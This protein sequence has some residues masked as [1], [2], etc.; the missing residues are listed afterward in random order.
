MDQKNQFII[1]Y[2]WRDAW[3]K[4]K[5]TLS[6][7]SWCAGRIIFSG[8]LF[9]FF[10]LITILSVSSRSL[11]AREE[12]NFLKNNN[13][14]VISDKAF[15][16]SK[17]STFEALGNVIITHKTNTIYSEKAS[18]NFETGEV[19]AIGNVRFIGP[20]ITMYGSVI[21]YN[22]KTKKLTIKNARVLSDNYIILGKKLSR[23][24]ENVII[25]EEAEYTTC[26]DCPESWSIFGK[27]IHI[28]LGEY[29]RIQHAYIK[30]KGV[31]SMYFPYLVFPIK[32]D[33][34]MGLLFPSFG[35]DLEEGVRFQQPWF[36]PINKSIDM[37]LTPSIFGKRGL[38]NEL[39][40]RHVLKDQF[41]YELNTFSINDRVYK[42]NSSNKSVSGEHHFRQMVDWEH[43]FFSGESFNHHF[44][45]NGVNDLDF[46]KDFSRFTKSRVQGTEYGGG[47]FATLRK[48][49]FTFSTE[50]HFNRNNLYFNPKGFDHRYVHI[51]PRLS[52][53]L[54]PIHLLQSDY[55]FLNR[56]SFLVDG[57]MTIFKQN[58]VAE[59]TYLR[60]A[61]RYNG[62]PKLEWNF[63]QFGVVSGKTKITLD[64]QHYRFPTQVEQKTFTK[65]GVIY[66]TEFSIELEKIYGLS[67]ENKVLTDRIREVKKKKA[68]QES[69]SEIIGKLP[70]YN[71][72]LIKK[73]FKYQKPSF[74]HSQIFKLK[75]YSIEALL[76][77]FEE[78]FFYN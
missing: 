60:N 28:T 63:G 29:V 77:Y 56:I 26:R 44:Y 12:F 19:K 4:L 10:L 2:R 75:H 36:L 14:Q 59:Q 18:I 50:G 53:S 24:S 64:Y 61:T 62:A 69:S 41:W 17:I 52:F 67:Y 8:N 7:H 73:Y 15:R 9:H 32:K 3:K 22:L 13:V 30:I 72:R 25:G 40:F 37:T 35:L 55:P 1:S 16:K 58:H 46:D 6:N 42:P 31:V 66:E 74:R 45:Y 54:I 21:E 49:W 65:S 78:G 51:L 11:F 33:R 68:K 27:N 71:S 48:D 43:H 23:I 47:G 57:D 20:R 70:D 34:Q 39:Q 38:A 76:Y 5:A